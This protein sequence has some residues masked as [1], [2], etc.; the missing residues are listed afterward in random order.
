MAKIEKLLILDL[1]NRATQI[2]EMI[3]PYLD[4]EIYEGLEYARTGEPLVGISV[5]DAVVER[6][7]VRHASVRRRFMERQGRTTIDELSSEYLAWR[8]DINKTNVAG[9]DNAIGALVRPEVRGGVAII[10]VRGYSPI[11]IQRWDQQPGICK[12]LRERYGIDPS[13]HTV[14]LIGLTDKKEAAFSTYKPEF[15]ELVERIIELLTPQLVEI[16]KFMDDQ[17]WVMFSR[18]WKG[19]DLYVEQGV[20][21]RV[22]DWQRRMS[23]GQWEY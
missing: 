21:Y 6:V 1:Y 2:Q 22:Y 8:D 15:L 16:A 18:Q 10:D 12:E 14:S 4:P 7:L 9:W 3:A 5:I 20:D 11:K 19:S 13:R 17:Y 23:T